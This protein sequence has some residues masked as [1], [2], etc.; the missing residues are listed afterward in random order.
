MAG[1]PTARDVLL[2]QVAE[3]VQS[4]MSSVANTYASLRENG[5]GSDI[6][7]VCGSETFDVHKNI[8]MTRSPVFKQALSDAR[9]KVS[10]YP[11]HQDYS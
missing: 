11:D 8:L 4:F 6:K 5:L 7:I 10:T 3:Y 1:T 2:Q 9:W